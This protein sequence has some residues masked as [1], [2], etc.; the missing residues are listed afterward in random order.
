MIGTT[1]LH[2][3]ILEKLG[4]VPLDEG[5]ALH[6]F[7]FGGVERAARWLTRLPYRLGL[8]AILTF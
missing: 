7:A 1:V 5:I 2:Y 6:F 3:S 4:Q 8:V